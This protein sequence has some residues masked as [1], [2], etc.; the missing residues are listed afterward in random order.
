[1]QTATQIL[2]S[3]NSVESQIVSL[4]SVR[5]KKSIGLIF[6]HYGNALMN[7]ILRVIPDKQM[8]EEVLQKVLL[9]V[10]ENAEQYDPQKAG[11]YSWLVAISRNAAL[12]QRKTR[13]FKQSQTSNSTLQVVTLENEPSTNN[14]L[15][16][17]MAK[18]LLEQL[19][20]KYKCLINMS[21]FEGYSH[22]EIAEKLDLPL[23][24]VKTRIRSALKHLRSFV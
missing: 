15:E 10:W 6:N 20:E 4:L 17:L 19:P 14:G 12:D 23:G 3:T 9:K 1:M 8:S 7:I 2:T 22:H 18:Q 24:T 5:D 21:F 13:D 16:K 11:L